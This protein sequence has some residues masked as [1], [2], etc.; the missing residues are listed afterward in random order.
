MS[1][2]AVITP[3]DPETERRRNELAVREEKAVSRFREEMRKG[4]LKCVKLPV[5][6]YSRTDLSTSSLTMNTG[7][8][9]L[10]R[11]AAEAMGYSAT[12]LEHGKVTLSHPDGS[13]I[14]ISKTKKGK[15]ALSSPKRNATTARMIVREYTAMQTYDH[16]KSRGMAVHSKRTPVGEITIEAHAGNRKMVVTDI[17]EDGV[18]VIDVSGVKGKGCQEIINGITK[19]IGGEQIDTTRKNDYFLNCEEEGGIHVQNKP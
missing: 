17:R 16:F 11:S 12:V 10:V 18:A 13:L 3:Y 5:G 6:E 9:D 8:M 2:T 1:T 15:I 19:A 7:S 4:R 14:N